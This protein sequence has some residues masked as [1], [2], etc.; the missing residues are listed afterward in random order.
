MTVPTAKGEAT[1]RRIL[2]AASAEFAEH[3]IAGARVDRIALIAQSN[4]A[5]MYTYF[6]SKDSL[7]DAVFD[8]HIEWIIDAVPL[9]GDD[10]PGYAVSLYE[11]YL[12]HPELVRLTTWRR[13]ERHPT[14]DL[15]ADGANHDSH[16]LDAVI[17]GQK[18]HHIDPQ[19]D[20]AD[21]L[22]LVTAMSMTWSPASALIAAAPTDTDALHQRRKEALALTVRRSFG[23]DGQ[24]LVRS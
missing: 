21:V 19:L 1:K 9:D 2:D 11:A 15:F 22:S 6:G 16:K 14:G 17:A 7:F 23:A 20:P 8:E 12:D 10:L 18:S 13:L 5:Q 24:K 3:G 4:K